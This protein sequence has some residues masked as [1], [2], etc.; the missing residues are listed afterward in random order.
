MSGKR[1]SLK[2]RA[3]IQT[4]S[5]RDRTEAGFGGVEVLPIGLLVMTI[6]TFVVLGAWR[7]IDA[8]VATGSAATEAART[9]VETFDTRQAARAGQAAWVGHGNTESLIAV[10][11]EGAVTRCGRITAIATT[12]V[13]P[14]RV[15]LVK[16]WTSI[17]VTS[18]HSALV[19]AYRNGNSG[20]ASCE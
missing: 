17:T 5:K 1:V 9:L 20:E 16:S 2:G 6:V 3:H 10:T 14:L 13:E 11:F 15:P 7:V 4:R 8:K 19:D 18:R 12:T